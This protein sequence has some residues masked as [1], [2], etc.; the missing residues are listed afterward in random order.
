MKVQSEGFAAYSDTGMAY[1]VFSPNLLQFGDQVSPHERIWYLG[2]NRVIAPYDKLYPDGRRDGEG[3]CSVC[4]RWKAG[5]DLGPPEEIPTLPDPDDTFTLE[6][7]KSC[8]ETD[9][10]KICCK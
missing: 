3:V 7:P 1:R 4:I 8:L 5:Q 6:P 9:T 2:I 10:C